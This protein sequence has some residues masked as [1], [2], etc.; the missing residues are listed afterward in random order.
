MYGAD[1]ATSAQ[2]FF[3][4]HLLSV[5]LANVDVNI[6]RGNHIDAHGVGV[7]VLPI[8]GRQ[9]TGQSRS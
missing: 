8:H 1:V 9:K 4:L 2:A 3:G 5:L 6:Y 7:T